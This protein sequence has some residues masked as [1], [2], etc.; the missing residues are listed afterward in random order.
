MQEEKRFANLCR[1]VEQISKSIDIKDMPDISIKEL[2]N[3]LRAHRDELEI[4]NM[5]LHKQKE[6]L[7]ESRRKY[8]NLYDSAP[9]GYFT[10]D[11]DGL[12]LDVNL[13]GAK[14]LGEGRNAL[15]DNNFYHYIDVCYQDIFSLHRKQIFAA[16]T[17][18][19]CEI[20]LKKKEG[21]RFYA[22]MQSVPVKDSKGDLSLFRTVVNDITERIETEEAFQKAYNIFE[23]NVKE[24][25]AELEKT[26]AEIQDSANKLLAM[27]ESVGARMTMI[28]KDLTIIWANDIARQ[29]FGNN[30]VGQKCHT[31]FHKSHEPC[32]P[33]PCY[34]LKAFEDGKVHRHETRVTD[35][36]GNLKYFDCIANVA[37]YDK[38]E[39]PKA[40]LEIARD[41]TM[42]KKLESELLKSQKLESV[43][44]LA[45]GIAHDF[46]NLLT[47]ILGNISL[48]RKL[49]PVGS[50]FLEIMIQVESASLQASELANRL[51][52]FSQGGEPL[53]R[54]V[55]PGELLI[56]SVNFALSGSNVQ[57]DFSIP[58]DL[59]NIKADQGQIGQVIQNIISNA[60][61][62]MPI[63]GTITV[64]AENITSITEDIPFL[65]KEKYI[66]ISITDQGPGIPEE[67]R[68]KI[69][70]PYFSTKQ[71][72]TQ[73]GMGLGLAICYSVMKKHHGYITGA[74]ETDGG[75]TFSIYLPASEATVEKKEKET[76]QA[77]AGGR[78]ATGTIL[79]MDDEK[80]VRLIA[81]EMLK[82][83]GYQFALASDEEEAIMLYRRAKESG[84]PFDAVIL[85][86]TIRGGRGGLETIKRLLAIDPNVKAIVSSGYRQNDVMRKFSEYG[87]KDAIPK[88]Y[89]IDQLGATLNRLLGE[90]N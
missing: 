29:L 73:K 10:F 66:K 11:K 82:L 41:I 51:I 89:N 25:L 83:I 5:E 71:A 85:D 22:Q 17:S 65:K 9:V 87:F 39:V 3:E 34:V 20:R 68:D 1:K 18:Q 64:N 80:R 69:F 45:G 48:A 58:D 56:K 86:L 54:I 76:A 14:L 57:C 4:Q 31:A 77:M 16:D 60:R 12:I 74:S 19:T 28:D 88:P 55:S 40:V 61:D 62:A 84:V 70:E 38:E 6:E 37:L 46:N 33:Q 52:T 59:W 15:I 79:V 78:K 49:L 30:I 53:A 24:R 47:A 32:P 81:G 35:K 36:D 7:E 13:A 44:R 26:N 2:I 8:Y 42:H 21:P 72:G 75:A 67:I 90:K 63:G 27:L 43:G 23:K 50:K